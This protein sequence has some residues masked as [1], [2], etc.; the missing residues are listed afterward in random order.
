MFILY[1][2]DGRL[3]KISPEYLGQ[4]K[5]VSHEMQLVKCYNLAQIRQGTSGKL[6]SCEKGLRA[7]PACKFNLTCNQ[8]EQRV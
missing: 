5:H 2:K 3:V 7:L 4:S 8:L 6:L 1:L